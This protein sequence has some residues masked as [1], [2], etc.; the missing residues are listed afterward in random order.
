M[1]NSL[2]S[3]FERVVVDSDSHIKTTA[4]RGKPL[5]NG[6]CAEHQ[7]AQTLLDVGA[8]LGY[9]R[10]QVT[11]YRAIGAGRGCWH[12]Y[13]RCAPT[14]W[15]QDDLPFIRQNFLAGERGRVMRYVQTPDG[16]GSLIG[17]RQEQQLLSCMSEGM[18]EK[19]RY[20]IGVVILN[21]GME[22]FY[23]PRMLSDAPP[24]VIEA[25]EQSHEAYI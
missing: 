10:I 3:P 9:P 23:S 13:A 22:R 5:T 14:R 6:W 19:L 17:N 16:L 20:K 8:Q 12:A 15:L 1:T 4:C 7:A 2:H 24:E 25:Y 18:Q 21:D 11:R